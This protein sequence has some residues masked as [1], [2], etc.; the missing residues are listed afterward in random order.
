MWGDITDTSFLKHVRF[1]VERSREFSEAKIHLFFLLESNYEYSYTTEN[2]NNTLK[3]A[4]KIQLKSQKY[5]YSWKLILTPITRSASD[6]LEITKVAAC[7][8]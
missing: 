3:D 6:V 8:V 7:S 5:I 2:W 1:L 4:N